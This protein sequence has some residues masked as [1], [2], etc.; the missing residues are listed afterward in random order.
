MKT[1]ENIDIDNLLEYLMEVNPISENTN[2]IENRFNC[3]VKVDTEQ[4][5]YLQYTYYYE[6]DFGFDENLFVQIE[7]G[8][9]NVTQVN[10]EEWGVS[11]MPSSRTVE[12]LKDII[13]NEFDFNN[14]C[15]RHKIKE[16]EKEFKKRIAIALFENNKAKLLKANK[17]QS[18][19]NYVT[20]G[21]TIKTNK[22]YRDEYAHLEEKGVFWEFVYEEVEADINFI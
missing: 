6:I 19:D 9:N 3:K 22:H 10:H 4:H 13:F 15:L 20:G 11:S 7:S 18:Y 1:K 14:W 16:S 5:N 17:N 8:I 21:G 12:V 2:D